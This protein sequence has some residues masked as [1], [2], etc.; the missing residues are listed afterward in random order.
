MDPLNNLGRNLIEVRL[1]VGVNRPPV[2]Q[3][4]SVETPRV[5]TLDGLLKGAGIHRVHA[6][7]G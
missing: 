6:V 5:N 4:N 2:R 7:F 3:E 1:G